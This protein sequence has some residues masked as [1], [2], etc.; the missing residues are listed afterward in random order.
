MDAALKPTT[1]KTYTSAQSRFLS[2]CS[3]YNQVPLPV[4]EDILLLYISY[5]FE[6]GLTASTIRVYLAAVRS[7]HI[8]SNFTYPTSML[9]VRL[10]LK[11]AV[12][13]SPLPNRKLP[14]T[15]H[16]LTQMLNHIRRRYDRTLLECVMTM[17]FFGCLRLA[18]C[19]VVDGQPFDK[20]IHLCLSDVQLDTSKKQYSLF[21]KR[22]KTDTDNHGITIYIGCSHNPSCCAFC[23]MLK[24]MSICKH[25]EF[26]DSTPLFILPTG[27]I[28]FKSYIV[29]ITRLLLSMS[30]YNP[31]HYSGH[32]YRAGAATTAGNN[33][34]RDW[35]VKLLGRW[36]SQAYTI[37]MRNPQITASFASRLAS[38]H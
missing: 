2:F 16:I 30:G 29:K 12:R 11:G 38:S 22:S 14:I 6:D 33:N 36:A 23:S 3:I 26:P 31:A 5:L 27:G 17:A 35:E 25:T 19:C 15:F 18:E 24:Y 1:T 10:A 21:L 32:S 7:L 8:F 37:Y 20:E 9:R 13:Q 28:L 4:T 34:F